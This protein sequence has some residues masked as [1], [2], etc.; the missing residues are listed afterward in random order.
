MRYFVEYLCTLYSLFLRTPDF[1]GGGAGLSSSS[2]D[3]Y[4]VILS[5]SRLD[6]IINSAR[7]LSYSVK[8]SLEDDH[9]NHTFY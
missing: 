1:F 2:F 7:T 5:M 9:V 4:H 6:S 8:G 3:V